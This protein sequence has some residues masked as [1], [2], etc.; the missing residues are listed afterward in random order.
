MTKSS[1]QLSTR[2]LLFISEFIMCRKSLSLKLD[3]YSYSHSALNEIW[4]RRS[5]CTHVIKNDLEM[6]LKLTLN[7]NNIRVR[8]SCGTVRVQDTSSGKFHVFTV[9]PIK[10]SALLSQVPTV[11]QNSGGHG[12]TPSPAVHA[13]SH[14]H[15]P[16]VQT[17]GPA[18]MTGHGHT[19]APP[20]S[21]Q[22]QQQFQRLKVSRTL[23][24]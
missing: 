2:V 11:A 13:G 17:H 3:L 4:Q 6:S 10:V 22:G 5:R 20:A 15:S 1:W 7:S 8:I 12:H 14:H 19:T 18:V 23:Q 16:A 21:V 9:T 24:F